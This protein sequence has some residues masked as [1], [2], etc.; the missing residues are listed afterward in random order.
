MINDGDKM[1]IGVDL[2]GTLIKD[3]GWKGGSHFGTPIPAMI[4]RVEKWVDDGIRVKIM[5]ARANP[6]VDTEEESY[7]DRMFCLRKWIVETFAER[8]DSIEITYEKDLYMVELWDDRCVQVEL[9]TGRRVD[10]KD[11]FGIRP[12]EPGFWRVKEKEKLNRGFVHYRVVKVVHWGN[13]LCVDP[14][15]P[16]KMV[17]RKR[18]FDCWAGKVSSLFGDRDENE[19]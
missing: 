7:S 4:E 11:T 6:L 13:D 18:W 16:L 2:D 8:A 14:F 9:N 1:W 10:M 3:T 19:V 17:E 15:L 12:N 5:T